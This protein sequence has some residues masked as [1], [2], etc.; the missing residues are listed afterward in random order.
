MH[1]STKYGCQ[2][3]IDTLGRSLPEPLKG[4][5]AVALSSFGDTEEVRVDL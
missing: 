5:C 2:Q 1:I 4:R 3:I